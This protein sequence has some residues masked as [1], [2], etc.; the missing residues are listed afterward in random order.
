MRRGHAARRR[1]RRS[2]EARAARCRTASGPGEAVPS[3]A[4]GM[5]SAAERRLQRGA[6]ALERRRD[7]RDR[8]RIGPRRGRARGSRRRR[9]R[10]LRAIRPLRGSAPRPREAAARRR[11][12]EEPSLEMREAGRAK[13]CEAGGSSSI[14]PAAC[15]ESVAAVRSSDAERQPPRLVRERD[16]D[17]RAS[18][19]RFDE[20]PLRAGQ[21]LEAIGIHRPPVPRVRARSPP[22]RRRSAARDRDPRRPSRSS[23]A[24]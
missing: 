15:R 22:A 20:R 13:L 12:R 9:A 18:R 23:S 16:G 10:A 1:A 4:Y 5:P 8:C 24:R 11:L 6:P 7:D 3:M 17:V 14:L 2:G 21:I 19:Q